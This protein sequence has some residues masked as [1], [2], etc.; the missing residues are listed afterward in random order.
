MD[1]VKNLSFNMNIVR[2]KIRK[3]EFF[4]SRFTQ[5]GMRNQR[6]PSPCIVGWES[7]V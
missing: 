4:H 7:L 6:N 5:V 2:I 1:F 3:N